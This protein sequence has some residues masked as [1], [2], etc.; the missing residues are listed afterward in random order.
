M[1]ARGGLERPGF[2]RVRILFFAGEVFPT[3]QLRRLRRALPGVGIY[4]LFGPRETNVCTYLGVPPDIP[5]DTIA[6]NPIGRACEHLETFVLDDDGRE[7][8]EGV[9]GTLWAR[10]GNLMQGDW[11]YPE[12][13]A[14]S[15]QPDPRGRSGFA[16]CTGDRVRLLASG[17]YQFLGRRD[18]MIK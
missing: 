10:G 2:G 4:N 1:L 9:E 15:V 11:K 12:P 6:P 14:A 5:D 3:P 13:T 18:H 16:Y 8:G 7:V 17:Y